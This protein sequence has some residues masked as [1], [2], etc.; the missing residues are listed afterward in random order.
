MLNHEAQLVIPGPRSGT[1]NPESAAAV[2]KTRYAE[3]P[4]YVTKD[5]S[6]IRELMHPAVHGNRLQSLAEATL[7][8]G[9][10]TPLHRHA[11]T[12]DLYHITS[13]SGLMTLGDTFERELL[14][15]RLWRSPERWELAR[16]E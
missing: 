3:I 2:T 15:S 9:M 8:P 7:A 14:R 12:E 11:V 10:R 16:Q 6:E 13:G 1:R 4:A 5:G